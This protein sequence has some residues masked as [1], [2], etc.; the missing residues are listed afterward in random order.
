MA[1]DKYSYLTLVLGYEF[2][3]HNSL[4]FIIV[5]NLIGW[6]Y[7]LEGEGTQLPNYQSKDESWKDTKAIFKYW[8]DFITAT[9]K[10]VMY[11]AFLAF[12]FFLQ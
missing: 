12:F 6:K 1:Q 2:L 3:D 5:L 10:T 7:L 11:A 8:A 9:F 4:K